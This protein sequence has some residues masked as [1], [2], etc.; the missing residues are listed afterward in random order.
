LLATIAVLVDQRQLFVF[1]LGAEGSAGLLMAVLMSARAGA[2]LAAGRVLDRTKSRTRLLLPAMALVAIGFA[3]LGLATSAVTAAMALLVIG[4][5]SGGLTIPMLTLLGDVTPP[6]LHGRALSVYQ[7]SSDFGGALGPAA[8]LELG[9]LVG[10]GPSYAG[11][12]LLMLA[13]ALP[14]CGLIARE[15]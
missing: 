8:G 11:V 15:R 5:G 7:W 2:S 1:G 12:G 4:V 10:F 9:R 13:M 6:H 3:G 14:L